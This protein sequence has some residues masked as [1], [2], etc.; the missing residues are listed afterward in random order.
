M[1]LQ[2][3]EEFNII[4]PDDKQ[5]NELIQQ[6]CGIL[7]VNTF[8]IRSQTDVNDLKLGGLYLEP[9]LMAH[10]CISN[11]HLTVDDEFQLSVFASVPIQKDEMICFSYTS[12]FMVTI[13]TINF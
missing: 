2:T 3:F 8:E 12:P 9:S 4:S 7:D 1:I 6:I 11:T 10:R 5:S 13:F